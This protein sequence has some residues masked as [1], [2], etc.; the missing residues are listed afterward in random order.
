MKLVLENM[1][2]DNYNRLESYIPKIRGYIE[3]LRAT[4]QDM[5]NL[6]FPKGDI[7][8]VIRDLGTREETV[9]VIFNFKP[10][11]PQV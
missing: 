2:E 7:L 1:E 5:S 10:F 8:T 6:Y 4:N 3:E 9:K 11:E